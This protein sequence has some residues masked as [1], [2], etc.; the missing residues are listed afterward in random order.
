MT[1]AS[2]NT[3]AKV[4]AEAK[5]RQRE[6]LKQRKD[7]KGILDPND[8]GG[9][10]DAERGLLTTLGGQLREITADDLRQ[11]ANHTQRLGK[12]FTG[13]ITAKQIVD[14]SMPDRRRRAN[15]EIRFAVPME[16]KGN[17]IHFVTNAGPDSRALRHHVYVAFPSLGAVAASAGQTPALARRLAAGQVQ[18][19]CDCE[20]WR[21]VFRYIATVGGYNAGR[22]ETGFPKLRNPKLRGI[23]CKHVLRTAHMLSQPAALMKIAQMIDLS[24]G[25]LDRNATKRVTKAEAEEIAKQQAKQAAWKRMQVESSSEKRERLAAARAIAQARRGE[26]P[27]PDSGV[28]QKPTPAQVRAA[29]ADLRKQMDILVA[30]GQMTRQRADAII[31]EAQGD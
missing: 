25:T 14:L 20:D 7:A 21:Y 16:I 17:R 4:I 10:Y 5:A 1:A 22:P 29:V 30:A 23:A 27:T 13:G 18:I 3:P 31:K 6:D 12:Q 8:V 2:A 15:E 9:R 19:E 28:S 24:R 26:R 11:F